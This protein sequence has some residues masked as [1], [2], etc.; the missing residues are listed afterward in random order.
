MTS[1]AKHTAGTAAGGRTADCRLCEGA[2]Y[3]YL[4]NSWFSSDGYRRSR[5]GICGGSGKS[6]Y[7]PGA[8]YIS[9]TKR[10]RRAAIAKAEGGAA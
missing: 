2:G 1:A 4:M 6:N 9:S 8:E 10:L 7:K 3:L 5:C